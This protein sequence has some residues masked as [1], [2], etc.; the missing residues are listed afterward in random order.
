LQDAPV[1]VSILQRAGST[2]VDLHIARHIAQ[3]VVVVEAA[4]TC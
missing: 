4:T 3:A 2:L 1:V